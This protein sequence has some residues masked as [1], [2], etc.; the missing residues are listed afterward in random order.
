MLSLVRIVSLSKEYNAGSNKTKAV[1]NVTIDIGR[2]TSIAIT[3]PSGC[4]KTTLL[5]MIGLIIPP[6]RGEIFIE[7]TNS[8]QLTEKQKANLRNSYFGYVVQNYAI[9]E[10]YSISENIEIPLYYARPSICKN[11]RRRRVK[12]VLE[13]VGLSNKVE[14]NV[15]NLSGGE[16]Q[17]VAIARALINNPQVILADEPTGSLDTKASEEIFNLLLEL[18][19]E[20]RT[21]I[22]VTHNQCL[23]NKCDRE[24]KMIDGS[25]K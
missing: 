10:K 20:G 3:G 22:M 15:L 14:E 8:N 5:N 7:S 11:E 9:I 23:A 16:K 19:H 21:L 18:V 4:G 6:S 13:K 25:I 1:S 12:E 2:G 24:L 17:R